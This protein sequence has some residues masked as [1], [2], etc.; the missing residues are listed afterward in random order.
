MILPKLLITG[1]SGLIGKTL[2]RGLADS[3]ELYGVDI[4]LS[5]Q[6]GNVFRADIS[7]QEQINAVFERIPALAYVVHLAGDPRAD[8]DW[9]SV[10]VNN[11][12]GTRNLYEAARAHGVKR[13][14]FASSNHVT[15]AYEG[16]PRHLHTQEN[17]ALIT[18]QHPIRPDGYYGVSKAAGEA[19]ARMYY[20]VHGLESI[21]LRIGSV[22]KD[23]DPAR[24]ARSQS[25]WLSHRDLVQLV[26]KSLL[27][28][29]RFAIY[30][31]VS[32]NRK[33]FWDISDA[34]AEIGYQPEDDAS[35][36]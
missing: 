22:L 31:G 28:E 27:A 18:T 29:V 25:I 20:E 7:N 30:Y 16:F 23:D 13:V 2:W 1:H 4:C 6:T 24:D 5:E 34:M 32:N 26:K 8:A 21:C 35:T 33:R 12:A 36:R 9:Q 19:I 11:I 15:G 17:P 14:V 3:F 10:L